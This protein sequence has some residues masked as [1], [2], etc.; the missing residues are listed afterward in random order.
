M[1][2]PYW[3]GIG[4][5]VRAIPEDDCDEER[6]CVVHLDGYESIEYEDF[7]EVMQ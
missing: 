6:F 4:I 5:I 3:E 1:W 2:L 7:M